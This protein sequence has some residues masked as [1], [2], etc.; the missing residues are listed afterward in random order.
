MDWEIF[1]GRFHPVLVHLPIGIFFLGFVLELLMRLT[2]RNQFTSRKTVILIYAIGLLAAVFA[3]ITGWLLSFSGD[4]RINALEDHKLLGIATIVMMLFVVIYQVRGSAEKDGPKLVASA[5]ALVLTGLTGHFGGNLTHGPDYLTQYAPRFI[6]SP[7]K[8]LFET[9]GTMHPDSVRI[10]PDLVQ[11]LIRAKCVDCHNSENNKGNLI[12]ENYEDLFKDKDHERPITAG[13]TKKS[14]LLRR[15]SLP[16]DHEKAMPPREAGFS[17]TDIRILNYWITNG[18]DSLARFDSENMSEELIS[19][20]QRDYGLDYSPRPYYEKVRVDS[21][22]E[23]SMEQLRKSGFRAKYLSQDNFLLDLSFTSDSIGKEHIQALN[24]VSGQV[25]LLKMSDCGLSDNQV[26]ELNDMLHLTR[27]DLSKNDLGE[28]SVS[29]M[30]AQ[31]NLEVVNLNET[32]IDK[33]LLQKLL[34][35]D[36]LRRVYVSHTNLKPD[37]LQ[38]LRQNHPEVEIIS[39]FRF[40]EVKEAKSVFTQE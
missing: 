10:Y 30:L 35:H 17:Y 23:E 15:I 24:R 13:D 27:M 4:Y 11:P 16:A 36:G 14:E 5:A 19:L 1:I 31:P 3:G 8:T 33:A 9:V 40:Q 32:H 12:L 21:L 20:M 28:R 7:E 25:T 2:P 38:S 34:K 29:F 18:A 26:G 37:E 39:D 22:S 6:S